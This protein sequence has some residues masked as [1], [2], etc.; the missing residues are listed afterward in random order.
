MGKFYPPK[1]YS[2]KDKGCLVYGDSIVPAN[3]EY[4]TRRGLENAIKELKK[5]GIEKGL[6]TRVYFETKS[7]KRRK[8]LLKKI[9]KRN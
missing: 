3:G 9:R 7:E 1:Q 4:F 2:K 6:S 5:I 8:N